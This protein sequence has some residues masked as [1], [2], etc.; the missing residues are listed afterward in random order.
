[1]SGAATATLCP[2]CGAA[3]L[4]PFFRIDSIPVFCNVFATSPTEASRA[5]CAD[6]ELGLCPAC[7][8]I[9]NVRFE[10]ALLDYS[11]EYENS[12]HFSQKFRAY[13][14]GL[15]TM[16]VRN[17]DLFDK[18]VIE[19][20]CGKGDFLAA[21]ARKSTS[22]CVGF[23]K[24]YED[25]QSFREMPNLRF[26]ADEFHP[27]TYEDCRADFIISRHV[28]EH[29]PDPR[30][31]LL[32]MRRALPDGGGF[33]FEVPNAM[34]QLQEFGIWDIIYEHCSYYTAP[35]LARLLR[36][37]G[38][39]PTAVH[40]S[41]GG[42]FLC[43]EGHTAPIPTDA[44]APESDDVVEIRDLATAFTREFERTILGWNDALALRLANGER[45]AIW[46]A[47]SKGVSFLNLIACGT[48]VAAVVDLN[49]RKQNRHVAGTAQRITSP[50]ELRGLAIDTV[51]VMNPNY[52]DEIAAQ[53][54]DLGMRC[55]VLVV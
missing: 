37:V 55:E 54:R 3:E 10:P 28:L 30:A 8:M 26:V 49:E 9:Y 1:M 22:R 42:Q 39:E 51:L 16:L 27:H 20:G 38:F 18:D 5:Q 11:P 50:E 29:V 41:F 31:F 7:A 15:A 45:I 36:S 35:S 34:F 6:L 13:A 52:R 21:I 47:G 23:D 4:E 33:Y 40:A 14:D 32:E 46:G 17:Y 2:A 19:V 24:S 53:L 48:Q 12:L 43:A 25:E 44:P